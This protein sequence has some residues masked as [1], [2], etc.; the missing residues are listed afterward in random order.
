[1]TLSVFKT[2]VG[3]IPSQ[4]G[5]IP[6]YSRHFSRD[7]PAAPVFQPRRPVA[8][9]S[10]PFRNGSLPAQRC[11]GNTPDRGAIVPASRQG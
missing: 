7:R 9:L 6:I 3:R 1:V 5:S 11:R 8:P 2:D 4:V 10:R